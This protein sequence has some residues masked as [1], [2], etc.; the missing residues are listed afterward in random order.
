[1]TSEYAPVSKKAPEKSVETRCVLRGGGGFFSEG[2]DGSGR[3]TQRCGGQLRLAKAK[4]YFYPERE[5]GGT[6]RQPNCL[7]WLAKCVFPPYCPGTMVNGTRIAQFE[8]SQLQVGDRIRFAQSRV[9]R[10]PT[11]NAEAEEVEWWVTERLPWSQH[12]AFF[13]A[14]GTLLYH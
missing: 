2:V 12:V 10:K 14:P 9:L 5:W 7:Q 4:V 1:M 13:P 11:A 3:V 6:A 8:P